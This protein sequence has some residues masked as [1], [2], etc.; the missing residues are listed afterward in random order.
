[1]SSPR[2]RSSSRQSWAWLLWLAFF[3]PLAQTAATW[4]VYSHVKEEAGG[5]AHEQHA[6]SLAHCDLCLT[7]AALSG[8]ALVGGNDVL[9]LVA[10]QEVVPQDPVASVWR[11][12]PAL[13]Y[14]SR[15][16]PNSAS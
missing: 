14:Q 10:A 6:P 4:H 13:A 8:G 2:L 11:A 15:A 12:L 7:A 5:H 1:M 16:P 3:L 9:P